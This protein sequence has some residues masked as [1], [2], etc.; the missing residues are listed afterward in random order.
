MSAEK[1][2]I[3]YGRV[4]GSAKPDREE[5]LALAEAIKGTVAGREFL[6]KNPIDAG[7]PNAPRENWVITCGD[8]SALQDGLYAEG[9]SG[10]GG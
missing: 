10:L 2:G 8:S 1:G 3:N 7:N 4:L 9:E 5:V 6:A